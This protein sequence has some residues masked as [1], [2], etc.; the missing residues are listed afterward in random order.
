VDRDASADI[1]SVRYRGRGPSSG[2]LFES[3][4][5]APEARAI[6]VTLEFRV[7][8]HFLRRLEERGRD[9]ARLVL[10]GDRLAA[11]GWLRP[12]HR[13]DYSFVIPGF[14]QIRLRLDRHHPGFVAVT[15][16]P[17]GGS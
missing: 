12:I 14:G 5:G 16:L 1:S 3:N 17:L 4:R 8:G 2:T 10:E 15:F 9:V 6:F 7:T 11:S 13:H